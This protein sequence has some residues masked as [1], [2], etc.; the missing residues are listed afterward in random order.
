MYIRYLDTASKSILSDKQSPTRVSPRKDTN[1]VSPGKDTS[2]H[3]LHK[4]CLGVQ[5]F[6]LCTGLGGDR[7]VGE[8]ILIFFFLFFFFWGGGGAQ[9]KFLL[10]SQSLKP[11][12][13]RSQRKHYEY[14]SDAID[15]SV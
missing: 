9:N 13:K 4:V 8:Q 7:G 14:R 11:C 1:N 2:N 6:C 12:T 3:K 10:P 5:V 15:L